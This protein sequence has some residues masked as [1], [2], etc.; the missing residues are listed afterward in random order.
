MAVVVPMDG[1]HYYRHELD[2]MA[3][4]KEAHARR[5]AHWTFDGEK[6]VDCIRQLKELGELKLPSFDHGVGDP[7]PESIAVHPHHI[8]VLVE[9]NYLLLDQPPWKELMSI[10]DETW[11]VDCP[12]DKAMERVYQRQT[13]N[14]L[15]PE[16]SRF[17]IAY[18]DRPNAELILGTKSRANLVVPSDV[19]W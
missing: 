5:G 13:G 4:P 12:V 10:F 14:G 18:N 11:F 7:V 9:G 19:P 3:D 2:K 17:R 6:F 1:F 8:I 16:V 15:A